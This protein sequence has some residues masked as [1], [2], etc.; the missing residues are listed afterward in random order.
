MSFD[1]NDSLINSNAPAQPLSS[2]ADIYP[3]EL[4]LIEEMQNTTDNLTR[5]HTILKE[6]L[7]T[8][9]SSINIPILMSLITVSEKRLRDLQEKLMTSLNTNLNPTPITPPH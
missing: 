6:T 9:D 5:L 3:T 1:R 7:L 4:A 8:P 2:R